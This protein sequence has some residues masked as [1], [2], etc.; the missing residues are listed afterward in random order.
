MILAL[1]IQALHTIKRF[2]PDVLKIDQSFVRTIVTDT[3][4]SA[5]I[6]AIVGCTALAIG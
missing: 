4:D 5:I 1:D 6:S 2:N 3:N